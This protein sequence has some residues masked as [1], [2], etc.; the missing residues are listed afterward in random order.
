MCGVRNHD[1]GNSWKW[2]ME[3]ERW[4]HKNSVRSHQESLRNQQ[5]L[6]DVQAL[7]EDSPES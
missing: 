5:Y 4:K 6:C 1:D 3:S 7:P 2:E